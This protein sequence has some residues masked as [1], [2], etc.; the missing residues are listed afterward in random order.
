MCDLRVGDV[1]QTEAFTE[2]RAIVKIE[3]ST[4]FGPKAMGRVGSVWLTPGHPVLV[5]GSWTHPF[6]V[7]IKPATFDINLNKIDH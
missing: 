5:D 6:E 3:T 1:V 7:L 4:V 2:G